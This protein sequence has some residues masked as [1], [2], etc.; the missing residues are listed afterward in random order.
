MSASSQGDSPKFNANNLYQEESFTDRKVGTIRRLTPICADGL[1]DED[2]R[3]IFMG[4]T[5]IMTAMGALP[6]TFEIPADN[7]EQAAAGFHEGATKAYQEAMKEMEEIRREQ[8][9]SIV[10]P[11]AGAASKLQL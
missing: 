1:P 9:S 4:Q 7:L 6:L 11:G 2:R 8:A 5:Q 10:V 3:L